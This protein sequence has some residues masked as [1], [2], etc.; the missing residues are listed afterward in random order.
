MYSVY[1]QLYDK[2]NARSLSPATRTPPSDAVNKTYDVSIHNIIVHESKL[3]LQ[4]SV[5]TLSHDKPNDVS[6][7][8]DIYLKS[9]Y[10]CIS[11]NFYKIRNI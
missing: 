11:F 8:S 9:N 7:H 6:I 10:G 1:F 2:I 4:M 3:W 5:L